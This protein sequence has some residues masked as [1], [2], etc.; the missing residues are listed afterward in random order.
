MQ[1]LSFTHR[2][3]NIKYNLILLVRIDAF[4]LK[5]LIIT[6]ALEPFFISLLNAYVSSTIVAKVRYNILRCRHYLYK[7]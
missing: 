4:F 3:T 6:G 2:V 7:S 5:L 1:L